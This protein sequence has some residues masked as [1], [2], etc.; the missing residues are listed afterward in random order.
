[1][2]NDWE[3][4]GFP[5]PP[6]QQPS[7]YVQTG[8]QEWTIAVRG[9]NK[10]CTTNGCQYAQACSLLQDARELLKERRNMATARWCDYSNHA[11]KAPDNPE[12]INIITLGGKSKEICPEDAA[13]LGLVDNY[14]APPESPAE[15]HKAIQNQ[16]HDRPER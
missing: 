4:L 3:N 9:A 1:M 16:V 11:Y 10:I 7:S 2:S 13:L 6:N 8:Q 14:E 15:R 12:E 5:Y